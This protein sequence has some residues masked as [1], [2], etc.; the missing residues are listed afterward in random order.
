[1]AADGRNTRRPGFDEWLTDP[2][3]GGWYWQKSYTRNG[4]LIEFD[5]EVY[6]PDAAHDFAIDFMRR[7]RKGRKNTL[8]VSGDR[9]LLQLRRVVRHNVLCLQLRQQPQHVP[10]LPGFYELP[11]GEARHRNS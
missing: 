2:A 9:Q 8:R 10:V 3:A 7:N 1:M 5:N 6:C 11:I 4:K